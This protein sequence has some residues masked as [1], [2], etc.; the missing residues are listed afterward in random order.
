VAT[1]SGCPAPVVE[2]VDTS[3]FGPVNAN[4]PHF[5]AIVADWASSTQLWSVSVEYELGSKIDNDPSESSDCSHDPGTASSDLCA[6]HAP[7]ET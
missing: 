7:P 3:T 4:N 5:Y 6:G 1:S 2:S